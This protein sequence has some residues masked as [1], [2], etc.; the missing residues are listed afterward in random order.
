[1]ASKASRNRYR[2]IRSVIASA[3]VLSFLPLLG[4]IRGGTHG[5]ALPTPVA[6]S[7]AIAVTNSEAVMASAAPVTPATQT[8]AA[9]STGAAAVTSTTSASKA[10]SSPKTASATYTRTKAS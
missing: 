7:A 8:S 10:S 5:D 9:Q 2:T 1:M 4:L 6:E 3:S